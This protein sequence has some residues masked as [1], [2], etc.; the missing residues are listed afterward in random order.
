MTDSQRSLSL[1]GPGRTELHGLHQWRGLM[2]SRRSRGRRGSG[3]FLSFSLIGEPPSH[4]AR[5]R[6]GG[7]KSMD[8]EEG[9]HRICRNPAQGL[10]NHLFVDP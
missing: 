7:G 10:G 3:T 8:V 4:T 9:V 2:Q 1:R 5:R 6:P